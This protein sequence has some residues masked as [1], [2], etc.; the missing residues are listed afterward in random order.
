[1]SACNFGSIVGY[2]AED[3]AFTDPESD[4]EEDVRDKDAG[5]EGV[6]FTDPASDDE[7]DVRD[8]D[9]GEEGALFTDPASDDEEDVRDKDAGEEGGQSAVLEVAEGGSSTTPG[10]CR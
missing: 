5:E 3:A 9:A 8:K 7:E 10:T 6:L 2:G 1:M 4:G